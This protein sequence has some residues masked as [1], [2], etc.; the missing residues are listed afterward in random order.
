MTNF[1]LRIDLAEKNISCQG[2]F[3]PSPP[4]GQSSVATTPSA[5]PGGKNKFG[6]GGFLFQGLKCTFLY[7][8]LT[9]LFILCYKSSSNLDLC[10]M[11]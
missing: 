7:N 1:H 9:L 4:L 6:K 8:R 2:F 5:Q 11:I 3:R 10:P